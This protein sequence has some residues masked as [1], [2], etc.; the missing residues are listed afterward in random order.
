MSLTPLVYTVYYTDYI[1]DYSIASWVLF[2]INGL[3]FKIGYRKYLAFVGC[4]LGELYIVNDNGK[5]QRKD[6]D[7]GLHAEL[8]KLVFS[9]LAAPA[10]PHFPN[11]T[12]PLSPPFSSWY[13][14]DPL[15]I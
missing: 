14:K 7:D 2:P 6:T 8:G 10:G 9:L 3:V 13:P 1:F 5:M 12:S 15:K 11:P 4:I